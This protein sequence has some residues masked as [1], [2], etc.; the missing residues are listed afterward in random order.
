MA[1]E[2]TRG[3]PMHGHPAGEPPKM[4]PP[5]EKQQLHKEAAAPPPYPRHGGG[6]GGGYPAAREPR[7]ALCAFIVISLF[8]L[9]VTALTLWLVYRPHHPRFRVVSAAVYQLNTSSPPFISATMQFSLLARNPN[10]RVS[11]YYESLSAFVSYRNFAITSPVIL[12]PLFQET[13][14]T[15]ALSPLVGGG[16]VAVEAAELGNAL[17]MDE[18]YGVV[19]VS[20]VLNGKLRYKAGAIRSGPHGIY[21]R[22]DLLLSFKKG[23]VGQLPLLGSPPCKVFI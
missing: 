5:D 22:C 19:G 12:P 23:F 6:G 11:I 1:E 7:R 20:L 10:K 9:G 14:S 13:K 3:E 18:A 21:V 16:P 17:A 8:L 2:E 15:V 4:A